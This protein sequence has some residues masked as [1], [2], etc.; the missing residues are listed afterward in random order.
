M[1]HAFARCLILRVPSEMSR[2]DSTWRFFGL[3]STMTVWSLHDPSTQQPPSHPPVVVPGRFCD[4]LKLGPVWV[5]N[6]RPPL[7]DGEEAE[8]SFD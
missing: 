3:H 4:K 7:I 5:R 2:A 1:I 6:L 8:Q